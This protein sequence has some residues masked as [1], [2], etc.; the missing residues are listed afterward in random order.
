MD[1]N[2]RIISRQFVKWHSAAFAGKDKERVHYFYPVRERAF[3]SGWRAA[4]EYLEAQEAPSTTS[5]TETG[6]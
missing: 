6:D 1:I 4:V 5:M 3:C 2:W